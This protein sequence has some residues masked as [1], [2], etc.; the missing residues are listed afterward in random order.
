MDNRLGDMQIFLA[1]AQSGSF[2]GAAR[3]LRLTPSAVSRAISRL[4]TR[5]GVQMVS[6]TTRA[7][8]LTAEGEV[9]LSLIHI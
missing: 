1:V 6:R 2:A 9:Y 8:S 3:A 5:I 4:E 7:L